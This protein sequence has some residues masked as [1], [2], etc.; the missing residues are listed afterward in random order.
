MFD[1]AARAMAAEGD[2]VAAHTATQARRLRKRRSEARTRLRLVADRALLTAHH[3]SAPPRMPSHPPSHD[4]QGAIAGL[5]S[6]QVSLMQLMS[7]LLAAFAKGMPS[8]ATAH[9]SAQ[10][11]SRGGEEASLLEEGW[12]NATNEF[13]GMPFAAAHFTAHSDDRRSVRLFGKHSMTWWRNSCASPNVFFEDGNVD[14]TL[15]FQGMPCVAT[16]HFL[17]HPVDLRLVR[18]FG[19]LSKTW[20]RNSRASPSA[21]HEDGNED[22]TT[23]FKGNPHAASAHF[24]A[25]PEDKRSVRVLSMLSQT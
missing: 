22:A 10:C 4:L 12:D 15:E 7:T 1:Q 6:Q 16:P 14:A 5:V 9:V 17:A 13:Q 20:W 18:V 21:F 2:V 23:E 24:S 8:V 11:A 19:E 25:R 3:A